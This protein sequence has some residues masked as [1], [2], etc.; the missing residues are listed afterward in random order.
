MTKYRVFGW[1]NYW[2]VWYYAIARNGILQGVV[3]HVSSTFLVY[4]HFC[5]CRIKGEMLRPS[6]A[7][8]ASF[9][10]SQKTRAVCL[11]RRLSE[12]P[13]F[14]ESRNVSTNLIRKFQVWNF[15]K[16]CPMWIAD[17]RTD[18]EAFRTRPNGRK[19]AMKC[20]CTEFF[21]FYPGRNL[22]LLYVL[23]NCGYRPWNSKQT[24]YV[25]SRKGFFVHA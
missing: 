4:P 13:E 12:P 16:I 5:S 3:Y 10:T 7:S 9:Y 24:L 15:T 6:A 11:D 19:K 18:D 21:F 8:R 14:D 25:K 2:S 22:D 20:R 1:C 23:N 17:G